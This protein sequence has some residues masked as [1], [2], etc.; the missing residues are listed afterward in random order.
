VNSPIGWLVIQRELTDSVHVKDAAEVWFTAVFSTP[1]RKIAGGNAAA[2][3]HESL[4]GAVRQALRDPA[5]GAPSAPPAVVVAPR[6]LIDEVRHV[7]REEG[8]RAAVDE[9][10]PPD[11]AEDVLTELTGHLAGRIQVADP[12]TPADWALL[13][14]QAGAYVAAQP[15]KRLADDVHLALE[16]RIGSARSEAV[17]VI[18]GSAG[19]T[20]GLALFA[21]RDVPA[22]VASG[23]RQTVMPEGAVHFSLIERDEAPRE[24][25][26]RA[27]RYGWP[28]TIDAPLFSAIEPN[29]PREIDREQAMRL[30]VALTA[31]TEHHRQGAGMGMQ[32]H[33]EIMLANGRRGRWRAV[34]KPN[35][36]LAVPPGLKLFSGEVRH[37]LFPEETVIGLGG[38]PWEELEWVRSRAAR[39]RSAHLHGAPAGDALPLLIVGMEPAAGEQVARELEAAQPEGVALIDVG[40]DVMIVIVTESGMHGVT[41]LPADEV[42]VARFRHRLRAADGWHAI[43]VSTPT[44]QRT[45][46]I[47]GFFECRLAQPAE[48]G[49]KRTPARSIRGRPKGRSSRR[50]R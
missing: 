17:A 31:A 38:L 13:H 43:M 2:S 12:P 30:T 47:Y 22:A 10:A 28:V 37:D 1:T 21:G 45:D 46:P 24:L 48:T 16:L 34:L 42:S 29:G 15:W 41:E 36:I 6:G 33:G 7:L 35:L 14:Q 32:V 27:I 11:W 5:Y 20:R 18:L 23:N 40:R 50:R 25:Q 3:G 8:V 4:V 44:G 39:H 9:V 19:I 49:V 26:E